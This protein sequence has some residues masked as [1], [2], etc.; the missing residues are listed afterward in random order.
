[1]R[2]APGGL[3]SPD[4]GRAVLPC[5]TP[6]MPRPTLPSLLVMSLCASCADGTVRAGDPADGAVDTPSPDVVGDD[7]ASPDVAAPRD[8]VAALDVTAAPDVTSGDVVSLRDVVSPRDVASLS[9]IVAPPCS[10]RIA[11]GSAWIHGPDH[12]AQFDDADGAVTWDGA[13]VDEGANSYAVLS[14]GWRP[15]FEGHGGCVIALDQSARCGAAGCA[16]RLTYARTWRHPSD[17]P[18]QYDDVAG[19]VTWSGAC[20]VDGAQ[21]YA[22]LSNGWQPHYDGACGVSLR[23]TQ[24]GGLYDNPAVDVDCPDPGVVRDGARYVMAC[25]SGDAASAFPL[26]TST[27]LVHWTAR[28]HVF[29]AGSRPSW[30]RGDF[31]APEVHRVGDRWIAYYSAR[32]ASDGSLALGAATAS[33]ALGPYTDLGHPLLHDPHPGVIDVSE[34]ETAD[35]ARYLLWKTDGNAVGAR[36]PIHVQRL[37][38]DG[39]SLVG[40]AT[41]VLTNDQSWE[42]GLVEGPWMISHDGLWYLFYS[43][44]N[45]ASTAYAV[46]V[47]RSASPTGPFV[48]APAPLLVSGGGWSGPGHGSVLQAPDGA[49]VHVYHAWVAGHVGMAP[50]RQV[51]VDRITW[52]AQW[53]QMR[54]APSS[55]SQPLP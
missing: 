34:F 52:E 16:T 51:L 49:W 28:G 3:P 23:Y 4:A 10:T 22:A 31:W 8:V 20:H 12:P 25:T 19:V 47:A 48:K 40:A 21:T 43:A 50:G 9:D 30:A 1:M 7:L 46:G 27:D 36:T 29:P 17:H 24:C 37:A 55:R 2:G 11:Y 32:M 26:R 14:N 53:P 33:D 41:T 5:A 42:G 6:A 18:A 38:D 44:N 35:H 54:A 15:Y 13:C 45:Y 39:L